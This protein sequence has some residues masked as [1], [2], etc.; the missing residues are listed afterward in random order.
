MSAFHPKWTFVSDSF[1]CSPEW[2]LTDR[3]AIITRMDIDPT[4][5]ER[6]FALARTG[7]YPGVEEIRV[8]LKAEG[9]EVSQLVGRTLLKQL[10][11]LC[12]VA[13]RATPDRR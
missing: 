5:L 1:E 13:R 10:R 2:P 6:A 4:P 9:Y 7:K 12:D 3:T 8:Q 11:L